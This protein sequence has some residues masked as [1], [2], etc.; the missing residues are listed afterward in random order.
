MP[1]R[2]ITR[3]DTLACVQAQD[4]SRSQSSAARGR[5]RKRLRRAALA[6]AIACAVFAAATA[7]ILVWPAAGMPAR[8]NAIVL[9]AGPGNLLGRAVGLAREHRAPYLVISLGTPESGNEC[10]ARISGVRIICFYPV[11]A[12]TQGEAEY[13]GRLARSHH[14]RSVA[15]VTITPQDTRARLRMG[16]CFAGHV[17]VV[18]VPPAP[19]QVNWPYEVVYQW[20]ALLK[21]LLFQRS[22]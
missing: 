9:M 5:R 15:L 16:R 10:A 4:V 21:A 22:C 14:W 17:Y 18:T 12:S 1:Q 11:P 20:G 19:S 13:V 6:L 3:P 7:R 8:V 2:G